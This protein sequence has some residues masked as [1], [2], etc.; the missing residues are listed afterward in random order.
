[1]GFGLRNLASAGEVDNF[2]GLRGDQKNIPLLVAIVIRLIGDPFSVGRPCGRGL[3]L[4]TDGE[5][6]GPSA[7]GGNE[8]E[9]VAPAHVGDEGDLL[10]VWRPRGAADLAG[11]VELFDGQALGLDLRVG[12]GG[13]LFGI[14]YG[15]GSLGAFGLEGFR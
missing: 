9:V 7:F 11:H 13:D 14:G 10:A 8:P 3:A 5:L 2:A 1:M 6:N 4:I 15:L 12:L